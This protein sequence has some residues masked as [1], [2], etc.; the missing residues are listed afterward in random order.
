MDEEG[1]EVLEDIGEAEGEDMIR[2]I[3]DSQIIILGIEGEQMEVTL[4]ITN[5]MLKRYLKKTMNSFIDLII[6]FLFI[7]TNK[8]S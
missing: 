2:T 1:K 4:I 7:N 3:E 8:N 5:K 6:S